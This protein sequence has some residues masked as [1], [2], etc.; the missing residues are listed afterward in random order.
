MRVLVFLPL[1]LLKIGLADGQLLLI[2]GGTTTLAVARCLQRVLVVADASKFGRDT[3]VRIAPLGLADTVVT[4][5]PPSPDVAAA[6]RQP[7]V[8]LVLPPTESD[9]NGV[10]GQGGQ[11]AVRGRK[12]V[13]GA[14]QA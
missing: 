11:P 9:P 12:P 10:A 3:F 8:T 6:L 5:Q 2:N 4:D 7:D 1:F 13:V 14:R